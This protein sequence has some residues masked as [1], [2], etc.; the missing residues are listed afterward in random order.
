MPLALPVTAL[1]FLQWPLR[2]L[3]GAGSTQANDLAQW[4]FALYVAVAMCHA[5]R[6]GM[7]LVARPDLALQGSPRVQRWRR[8]GAAICLL[9]WSVYLAFSSSPLLWHAL[10]SAERFPETLNPGYFLI[11]LAL[12]LIGPL[13]A[14]QALGELRGIW[15]S[16]PR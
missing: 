1:L 8:S 15:L 6:R 12:W 7:H 14:L 9:P 10:Q 2:D 5:Q 11:K 4:L 3:V 13:L 16:K